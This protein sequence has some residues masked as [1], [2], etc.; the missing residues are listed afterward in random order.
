M[1]GVSSSVNA[2]AFHLS[3]ALKLIAP[4][5]QHKGGSVTGTLFTDSSLQLKIP[6]ACIPHSPPS[7]GKRLELRQCKR[8]SL[9]PPPHQRGHY[10]RHD[11]HRTARA[12]HSHTG[13]AWKG[14]RGFVGGN[15]G[16]FIITNTI[17]GG[18]IKASVKGSYKAT[19]RV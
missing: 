4:T 11:E 5:A 8:V 18:P 1:S 12:G 10:L 15:K 13:A 3:D 19:R 16:A 14:G 2:V 7:T 9:K 17:L 6:A